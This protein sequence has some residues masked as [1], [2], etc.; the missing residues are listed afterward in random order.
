MGPPDVCRVVVEDEGS[1]AVVEE[2]V[3]SAF[4]TTTVFFFVDPLP[5]HLT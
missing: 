1:E 5:F 2:R 4:I 3:P